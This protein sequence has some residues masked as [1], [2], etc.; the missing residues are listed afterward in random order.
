MNIS[1]DKIKMNVVNTAE[2]GVVNRDTVFSFTQTENIVTAEYAGG[3]ISKGFLVGICDGSLLTF[4]FCQLQTDGSL[5]SGLSSCGIETKE[6]GK[7]R[8]TEHFEWKTRPGEKGINIFE[9]L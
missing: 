2:N 8:L 1:L 6:N 3:R 4:S 7:L 9:E 5:D